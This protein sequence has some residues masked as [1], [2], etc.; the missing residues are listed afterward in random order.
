MI[1]YDEMAIK[2]Q[3]ENWT[4]LIDG[5][6]RTPNAE[7]IENMVSQMKENLLSNGDPRGSSLTE[8]RF[9]MRRIN[10][11]IDLYLYQ[12]DLNG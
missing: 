1:D 2:F 9:H 4:W 7:E 11:H 8:G 3:I 6:H 5:F 12:G 10:D